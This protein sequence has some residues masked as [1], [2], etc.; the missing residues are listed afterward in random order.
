MMRTKRAA[1]AY[2]PTAGRLLGIIGLLLGLG[3]C[4]A[5]DPAPSLRYDGRYSGTR[6]S[7]S[8]AACG[9]AQLQGTLAARISQG[10]FSLP[11]FSRK[12]EL[13]GTVGE[14]GRVRASGIWPN[15]TG[16]FPGMTVLDGIVTDDRLDATATDFRCHT[17]LHLRRIQSPRPAEP[18]ERRGGRGG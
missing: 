4:S 18:A 5:T 2:S 16:G 13:T 15:P 14:S 6:Q 10:H 7:D 11:L 3:A 1:G 8:L 17:E 9:I 12:T